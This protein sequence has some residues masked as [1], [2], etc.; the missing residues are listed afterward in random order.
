MS[1]TSKKLATK[2]LSTVLLLLSLNAGAAQLV[3][4]RPDDTLSASVAKG[5]PTLIRIEGHRI[6]RIFGAEGDFS[7]IADK[8]SG[9]AYIQPSGDKGAFTVFVADDIG[10]TWKLLL[11]VTNGPVDSITIKGKGGDVGNKAAWRDQSRNKAIKRVIFA[12]ENDASDSDGSVVN[13]VIPLWSEARFVLLKEI[14][15]A[16]KG[17]K[18]QLSN[19]SN[20]DMVIDERELYRR[21]V[22]AVSIEKPVIAPG[23]TTMIYV[24]SEAEQ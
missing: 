11:G 23:E 7:V 10:R 22:V 18:Y 9:S 13:K 12:L 14:D 16:F 3:Q 2:T 15:G 20:A 19:I 21:N 24:V 8:E 17:E 1:P 4:G 6:R 5:E